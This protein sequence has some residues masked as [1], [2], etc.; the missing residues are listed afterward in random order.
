MS[1]EQ[2]LPMDVAADE[3]VWEAGKNVFQSME[4]QLL[5]SENVTAILPD[6]TRLRFFTDEQLLSHDY[7]NEAS[8]KLVLQDVKKK[9]E[10]DKN[11][12][13]LVMVSL[14]KFNPCLVEQFQEK[15][16]Q[17]ISGRKEKNLMRRRADDRSAHRANYCS[18]NR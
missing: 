9:I 12:L 15:V 16:R 13:P 10:E 14:K 17:E 1:Q 4:S 8:P 18:T 3:L 11:S 7:M 6:L 5:T 2:Q